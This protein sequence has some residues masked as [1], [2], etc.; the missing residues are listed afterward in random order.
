MRPVPPWL[1]DENNKLQHGV[2][3]RRQRCFSFRHSRRRQLRK[4]PRGAWFTSAD[5]RRLARVHHEEPSAIAGG[6][7]HQEG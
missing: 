7:A 5:F 6:S 4:Q 1:E 2:R 3:F